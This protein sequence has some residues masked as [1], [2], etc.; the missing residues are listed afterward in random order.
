LVTEPTKIISDDRRFQLLVDAVTDYAIYMLDESGCVAS[1]NSG[2]QRIKGYKREEVLGRHF[3][4]FF[5]PEDVRT[6]LP[7]HALETARKSGRFESEGWRLRKD[8]TRFWALAVLEAVHDETGRHIGFAKV[9]RDIT[10]RRAAQEAVRESE[11]QFRLLVEGVIDYAIYMLDPNGHVTSWNT[12]ARRIKGYD[13]EEVIGR[14]FSSFYTEVDHAAGVPAR[15]LAAATE[16]GRYEAEGWRVRKDGTLFWAS[17]VIDAI[18]DEQGTLIGF[19]KITRDITERREAQATL[20]EAQEQLAHAQKMETLGQ[21]T[22][23]VAHD[24]NNLL[25]IVSGHTQLLKKRLTDPKDLRAIEAIQ[26]AA[27]RGESLTRQLLAFSRRQRLKPVVVNLNEHVANFREMLSSSI[28]STIQL[29]TEIPSEIWPIRADVSELQLAL[30]NI[31]VNARD[32]MPE[33]GS[34]TISA[35]NV[36]VTRGQLTPDLE[37]DFVAISLVDTGCGIPPDILPKIFDPFFTTKQVDKGTGLGLSQVFGFAHQSGGTITVQ[38]DVG[39]GTQVTLYMPRADAEEPVAKRKNSAPI[40]SA[41][42]TILLV[43]DNPEVA[44]VSSALLEQLG[45]QS[46]IVNSADAALEELGRGNLFD[47]VFSDI[48]MAGTIDGVALARI[49]R[50]RYP[51]LP[52]LLS[53]GYNKAANSG[54][55]DFPVLR[56]PYKITE[57]G[58]AVSELIAES[59]RAEGDAARQPRVSRR[60]R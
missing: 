26:L 19:A 59:N 12:G 16:H 15:A 29:T 30:V 41:T 47:L 36:Q 52:V 6:G 17:V 5:T 28:R 3:G 56:K 7:Q 34:L 39:R 9:T 14:H 55:V 2:A 53:T 13:A 1:W 11:R 31:A 45:Y 4:L 51:K 35:R 46:H 27:S 58:R 33:G 25:M 60:S 21:L 23:G 10:E 50:E 43:E 48:V 37:G 57:L 38:S 44:R 22:G 32:A 18:R 20:E 40:E 49:V 8:G 24:F 54:D 42:G